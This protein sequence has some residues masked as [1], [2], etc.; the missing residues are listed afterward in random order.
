MV[1]IIGLLLAFSVLPIVASF[2]L[3]FFK[4]E[5]LQPLEFLGLGNYIYAFTRDPVFH[6][7]I[8]NT[9]YYALVSVSLG[10]AVSLMV[11]QFIHNRPRFKSFFRTV[12][13]LPVVTPAISTAIIWRFIFQPSQFGFLNA[14]ISYIGIPAQPW[15]TS[16]P[17]V[18]PA[19][20]V[21]G[22]WGGLGYNMV[23]FLAGLAGIPF[24]FYEAAKIDG[25]NSWQMFWKITWPLLSPTVLFTTVTGTI[26]ALQLFSTP[27]VMTRGGPENA[28]RT[29]VMWIQ[30]VGFDQFRMGYSSALAYIFFVIILIMT[31]LQLRYMKTQWSY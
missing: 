17:L 16:A 10:M 1:P 23:L 18:K 22:I 4:Y 25:A 9:F 21:I 2:Y 24:T 14:L 26:S 7:T 30:Q 29:V 13:F 27:F 8:L 6:E 20:V 12:Y 28:S 11:A 31:L 19:L 15:L 3:S 5:M